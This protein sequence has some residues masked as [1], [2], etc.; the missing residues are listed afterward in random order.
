[1]LTLEDRSSVSTNSS[2]EVRPR[3]ITQMQKKITDEMH[4]LNT[5]RQKFVIFEPRTVLGTQTTCEGRERECV[6]GVCVWG[7][8]KMG[9]ERAIEGEKIEDSGEE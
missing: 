6:E 8:G 5:V 9:K 4:H 3:S 1:M 7:A 2:E